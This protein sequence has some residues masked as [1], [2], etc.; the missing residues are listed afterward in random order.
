MPGGRNQLAPPPLL[1]GGPVW[2][3]SGGTPASG[4]VPSGAPGWSFGDFQQL[5]TAPPQQTYTGAIPTPPNNYAATSAE[6]PHD[7]YQ[8]QQLMNQYGPNNPQL[9]QLLQ[10]LY[11]RHQGR[12]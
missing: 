6:V 1:S 11:L 5:P 7:Y 12:T 8:M 10:L 4:P 2:S 9:N 3:D